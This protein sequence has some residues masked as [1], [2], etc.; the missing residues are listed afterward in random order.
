MYDDFRKWYEKNEH[1]LNHLFHHNSIVFDRL[2]DIVRVLLFILDLDKKEI[3]DDLDFT[4]DVGYAYLYNRVS[5]IELYLEQYF[6][7]DLHQF[8][9]YEELINYA[10]YLDDL[11][12]VLKEKEIYS[13]FVREGIE[14]IASR[15]EEIIQKKK[16]FKSEII[17]EFNAILLSVLPSHEELL[18]TPEIFMRIAEELQI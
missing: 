15:V 8:L 18:T 4:F 5:E 1:F 16:Q 6:K 10:L 11:V 3:S 2:N 12:E 13:E 7:N 17:D 14:E 9:K